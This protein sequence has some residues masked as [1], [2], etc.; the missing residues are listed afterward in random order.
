[1]GMVDDFVIPIKHVGFVG[2]EIIT[3]LMVKSTEKLEIILHY[4]VFDP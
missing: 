4:N 2:I 1:M 3:D